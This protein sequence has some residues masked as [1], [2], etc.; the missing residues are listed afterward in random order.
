MCMRARA[1]THIHTHTHTHTR[2]FGI[3]KEGDSDTG[4]IMDEPRGHYVITLRGKLQLENDIRCIASLIYGAK[5]FFFLN[6]YIH[7]TVC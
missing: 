4:D 5:T 3:K 7:K 1:H 6:R 2:L